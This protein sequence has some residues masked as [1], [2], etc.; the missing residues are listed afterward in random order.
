[1]FHLLAARKAEIVKKHQPRKTES[2]KKNKPAPATLAPTTAHP[3]M[4]AL[5]MVATMPQAA[6]AS[7]V[8]SV[9]RSWD[10][11]SLEGIDTL[12]V[13]MIVLGA[14]ISITVLAITMV[15]NGNDEINDYD[16]HGDYDFR[17]NHEAQR[18]EVLA[19]IRDHNPNAADPGCRTSVSLVDG[20]GELFP[21]LIDIMDVSYNEDGLEQSY[22]AR[23]QAIAR[24]VSVTSWASLAA[25]VAAQQARMSF[26]MTMNWRPK[27]Y[28]AHTK[29]T[30]E[31]DDE[32]RQL[33]S[34]LHV[35]T[36][37]QQL[38][39]PAEYYYQKHGVW[40]DS[41]S[42]FDHNITQPVEDYF[43]R[44]YPGIT[45]KQAIVH[46]IPEDCPVILGYWLLNAD[47]DEVL[48]YVPPE[49]DPLGPAYKLLPLSPESW[50][51]AYYLKWRRENY[52]D[53]R[54]PIWFE[55]D[56]SLPQVRAWRA[57][58][59][60]V[61]LTIRVSTTLAPVTLPEWIRELV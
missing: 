24:A 28:S 45:T 60:T 7:A 35:S 8:S 15:W 48:E 34:N 10:A 53:G 9:S 5:A 49:I 3:G 19:Q 36:Q 6:S 16:D 22:K 31:D 26:L 23:I 56:H 51:L 1:M 37:I 47:N 52:P 2:V 44:K 25:N 61:Q 46:P 14:L 11:R 50:Y 42:E 20:I 57:A 43:H 27:S 21:K 13:Y 30:P 33:M 55:D 59:P 4:A 58:N 32:V 41:C 38:L 40:V 17:R 54:P 12:H 18:E 39:T 29:S